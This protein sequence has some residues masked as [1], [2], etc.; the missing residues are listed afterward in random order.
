MDKRKTKVIV[1]EVT[2]PSLADATKH[3]GAGNIRKV[4]ARI[5][6]GWTI[7]QALNLTNKKPNDH[8]KVTVRGVEYKSI[9]DAIATFCPDTP[10]AIV[11]D[12]V[13]KLDW[14]L[15]EALTLTHKV[16]PHR[17]AIEVNGKVYQ[18]QNE[19]ARQQGI[20]IHTFRNRLANDHSADD[21]LDSEFEKRAGF[22]AHSLPFFAGG[23]LFTNMRGYLDY[24]TPHEK[25]DNL[26]AA[27]IQR[28]QSNL[29]D[30]RKANKIAGLSVRELSELLGVSLPKYQ[31]DE[32]EFWEGVDVHE[33]DLLSYFPD[34][35]EYFE[36]WKARQIKKGNL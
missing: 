33:V 12:R 17:T 29:S 22:P 16:R 34:L 3:F 8:R 20:N 5:R 14:S 13:R 28:H 36:G 6:S 4:R 19:A 26:T 2:F 23:E 21:A 10:L 32:Q 25:L 15:E 9:T 30:Y 31:D 11:L 7:E 18:S 35:S 1:N 24:I 27:K